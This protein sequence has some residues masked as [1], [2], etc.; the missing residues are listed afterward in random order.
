VDEHAYAGS[1]KYGPIGLTEHAS[2]LAGLT[3]IEPSDGSL[4]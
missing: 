4:R 3:I 2:A 1:H